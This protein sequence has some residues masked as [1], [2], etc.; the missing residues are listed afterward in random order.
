M[1]R[2]WAWGAAES[3]VPERLGEGG[4]S[5]VPGRK[6]DRAPADKAE[7]KKECRMGFSPYCRWDSF[8]RNPLMG[9]LQEGPAHEPPP[10]N[11]GVD[12]RG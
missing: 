7:V 10:E 6:R 5:H 11:V 4:R 12:T 2:L 8:R 3:D 1:G 9:R